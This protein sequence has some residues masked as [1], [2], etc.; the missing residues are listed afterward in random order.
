MKELTEEQLRSAIESD[1]EN[2]ELYYELGL[3]IIKNLGKRFKR[4]LKSMNIHYS[5]KEQFLKAS[6]LN[7]AEPKYHF[8]LGKFYLSV[9]DYGRTINEFNVCLGLNY[10]VD[11]CRKMVQKSEEKKLKE[12]DDRLN[13]LLKAIEK[14]PKKAK[15]Y[16]QL[17]R[18]YAEKKKDKTK[19]FEYFQ[20]AR[21]L[22]PNDTF[23]LQGLAKIY[24]DIGQPD[25]ALECYDILIE[26]DSKGDNFSSQLEIYYQQIA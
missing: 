3:L 4:T 24:S 10:R 21:E 25:K 8:E 20:K 17:G 15:N 11:E 6:K 22:D 23:C 13:K 2:P 14:Y 18:L 19:A 26:L 12:E 1:P 16:T 5:A 9:D 7:R